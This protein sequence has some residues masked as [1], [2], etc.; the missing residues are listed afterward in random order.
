MERSCSFG[1]L[2]R[3]VKEESLNRF[4]KE[5]EE[6]YFG[7][8]SS[9]D[10]RLEMA[11]TSYPSEH[12]DQFP[13]D[14]LPDETYSFIRDSA[15]YDLTD[16]SSDTLHSSKR[17]RSESLSSKGLSR[18][19]TRISTISAKWRYK[20]SSGG[21]FVEETFGDDLRSRANSTS[22]AF[23][24]ATTRVN[25]HGSMSPTPFAHEIRLSDGSLAPIDMETA[26]YASLEEGD[27]GEGED[28]DL[29]ASTPL[30]PPFL[31]D[32]PSLVAKSGMSSPL[33]S[34]SVAE[35][36]EETDVVT[37]MSAS[38][39]SIHPSPPLSTKPSL[40]SMSRGRGC[41]MRTI[42]GEGAP[43]LVLTELN[44]EWASKLGHANFT[45]QPEPYVPES[46]DPIAFRH[47]REDWDVARC[48]YA[49]HLV[50]TGEHYGVTSLI[51]RLTEEK[52]DSIE[53]KWKQNYGTIVTDG[54]KFGA[55][56]GLTMS[57]FRLTEAVKIPRLHDNDKF[58]ELGDEEIVGPM[59]VGPALPSPTR[60]KSDKKRSVVQF[61]HNLVGR[62]QQPGIA[63]GRA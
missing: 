51:Y 23:F 8:G 63:V 38:S 25:S 4:S 30:L 2:L 33:Q 26:N 46:C 47:F 62:S 27:E 6:E 18:I 3:G 54:A 40:A 37:S 1:P 61:F 15:E 42:S 56:L 13:S 39:S 34:P 10:H 57:N 45:I 48:N 29:K 43:P 17:R 44:D 21:D 11:L 49:K 7:T 36:G 52:W 58:P 16:R 41:T 9:A 55:V 14:P 5:M 59:S 60:N 24:N 32:Y 19:G 22:S 35:V 28:I 12:F 31:S 50:R 20:H 53:R